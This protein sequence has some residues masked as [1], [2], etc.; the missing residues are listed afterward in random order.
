MRHSAQRLTK[1][2]GQEGRARVI[3]AS[4]RAE[5]MRQL[6]Q[7]GRLSQTKIKA[8]VEAA[9]GKTRDE[10]QEIVEGAVASFRGEVKRG[11][12]ASLMSWRRLLGAPRA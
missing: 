12:D 1:R 5:Y 8:M 6:E 11:R 2:K 4:M 10:A 7:S 3:M 9:F